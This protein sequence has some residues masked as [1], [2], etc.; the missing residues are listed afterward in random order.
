MIGY[1]KKF[2]CHKNIFLSVCK[3]LGKINSD[4]FSLREGEIISTDRSSL[5]IRFVIDNKK[6][7]ITKKSYNQSPK[8]GKNISSH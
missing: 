8:L 1:K 3:I 6:N 4:L 7:L 5:K 2:Y